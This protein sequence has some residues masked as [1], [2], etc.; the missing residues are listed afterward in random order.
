MCLIM[1]TR[2]ELGGATFF[3]ARLVAWLN[4]EPTMKRLACLLLLVCSTAE[5]QV[6]NDGGLHVVDGPADSLQIA[7][8]TTVTMR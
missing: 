4:G 5:A 6:F 2:R 8:R 3:R 7:A 1:P